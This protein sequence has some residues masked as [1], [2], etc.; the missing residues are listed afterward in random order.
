MASA[1]AFQT[2]FTWRVLLIAVVSNEISCSSSSSSS[3]GTCSAIRSNCRMSELTSGLSE[4]FRFDLRT[5]SSALAGDSDVEG[6]SFFMGGGFTSTFCSTVGGLLGSTGTV[7]VGGGV[8]GIT[9]IVVE[10]GIFSGT[11][12]I[13]D[14]DSVT[15]TPPLSRVGTVGEGVVAVRV[16]GAEG[17]INFGGSKGPAMA[18]F[19]VTS[20]IV[21]VFSCRSSILP[22]N[23]FVL[24]LSSSSSLYEMMP[25]SG[26]LTLAGGVAADTVGEGLLRASLAAD[27][28]CPFFESAPP[29]GS[30]RN[31]GN[32]T[33]TFLAA[34]AGLLS[35]RR[36]P[37]QARNA[38]S[39]ETVALPQ[40]RVHVVISR[41]VV[42]R[43]RV[44]ERVS[45][46]PS[47]QI[48][49]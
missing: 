3:S 23:L 40:A 14:E 46:L 7:V 21:T 4:V 36:R 31:R 42:L 32:I 28:L 35:P 25:F 38:S 29:S 44:N 43:Q 30:R 10:A 19:V 1:S 6:G 48:P 8:A 15:V 18:T 5:R 22:S 17:E 2:P 26:G 13:G 27:A 47:L 37:S 12:L 41:R 9:V 33:L 20:L 24:L 49:R 34:S 39:P 11:I 45:P 16:P